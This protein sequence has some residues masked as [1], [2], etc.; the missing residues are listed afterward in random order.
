MALH[1]VTGYRGFA[2]IT[3]AD[4]GLFNAGS[5]G[6]G[7]Y[8]LA[9]GDQ[10]K[11]EVIDNSV[12]IYG[13]C[14]V[15]NG[16]QVNLDSPTN[17]GASN[18]TGERNDLI[19]VRYTKNQLTG[20]ESVELTRINGGTSDP[21]YNTGSILEGDATHDMPLYRV[22]MQGLNIMGVE[23]LFRVVSPLADIQGGQNLLLNSDFNSN[24]RGSKSYTGD[25]V[26]YSVDMWRIYSVK[27]DVLNEGV[28]VTGTSATNQGYLTQFIQLGELKN[29][30][31]TISAMVDRKI[32]TF[33][34]TPNT[35]KSMEKDFGNFKLSMILVSESGNN[36]LK[37]N[38]CPNGT[39]SIN[40]SY[41][42]VFEGFVAYPH[43]KEDPAVALMRCRRYVQGGASVCPT[44]YLY[45][46]GTTY[47][48]RFAITHDHMVSTPT[49]ESC[50][51]HYFNTAGTDT[52]GT[53]ADLTLMGNSNNVVQLKTAFKE[54]KNAQCNGIR[55][56]YILSCEYK[57]NGD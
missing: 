53:V 47:G 23:P 33:T 8:V 41:V 5:I 35:T 44:L 40:L 43:T 24:Q 32:C 27:L 50:S 18:G 15:M 52:T 22:K 12:R 4:Q 45:T 57:P 37:V 16:R 39:S 21:S 55:A 28:K 6:M 11:A 48:Y 38:I 26:K 29:T 19:V 30:T 17:V 3:S 31:Y 10:F 7:D 54:Q 20:I 42:D 13:G 9:V 34:A 2:H 36:K 49:L 46:E 56:V 14:L 25:T 51:W 1:L